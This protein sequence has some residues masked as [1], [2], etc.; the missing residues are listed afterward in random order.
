[1]ATDTVSSKTTSRI[2]ELDYLKC[3]MIVLMISFHLVYIEELHPYAKQ[4]VYTFHM[5]VFMLISGYL[6]KIDKAAK[7][8]FRTILWLVVPYIVMESG[9]TVMASMLPIR[10]HIDNLTLGV[11]LNKLLINPLGPYWYLHSLI[12]CGITYYAL[13]HIAKIQ[14]L[15]RFI[16]LGISHFLYS[17]IDIISMP[18]AFYFLAGT[19]IRQSSFEFLQIFRPSFLSLPAI[20]LLIINPDNLRAGSIGGVLIVY[21][22]VS[23]CLAV[24][25]YLKNNLRGGMLFI[26]RN[27][28]P[29][30]LFSPIFTIICKQ[31]IPALSFDPTGMLFLLASVLICVSGSLAISWL[32]DLCR[33]SPFFIG[34]A[35][36]IS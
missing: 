1:M 34:R 27:T 29:I 4:V 9:Y 15:T 16:L 22:T 26:G 7:A 19:I 13:F 28:L 12:L 32:I 5:P 25:P 18:L 6:M 2:D 20:I 11:F 8:F 30:F 17:K 36:I 24:Y 10:E 31:L 3:I 23:L 21:L 33:L 35:K 14:N